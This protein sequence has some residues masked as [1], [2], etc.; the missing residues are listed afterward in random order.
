[1]DAVGPEV[2]T[3]D[4]LVRLIAKTVRSRARFVHVNPSLALFLSQLIGYVVGDVVLTREE[5]DGLIA[6][7]LISHGPPTGRTHLSGWLAENAGTVGTHYASE[8]RRHYR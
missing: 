6:D 7:L 8:V 1:M 4:T 3:F 5:V 2:Y